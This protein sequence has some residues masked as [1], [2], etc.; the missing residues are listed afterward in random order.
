MKAVAI[1]PA[2]IGSSR[3]PR[4]PLSTLGG[5]LVINR[6]WESVQASGLFEQVIVATDSEE[7]LNAVIVAGGRAQMTRP[8]HPSGS[9]RVAEVAQGLDVYI[10]SNVQ[11]DEPFIDGEALRN[12]L[13]CFD[14]PAVE[15][16]SLMTPCLDPLVLRDPNI[17]KVITDL[18]G[19]ALYFSR[20]PI[21]YD[22]DG[23][24]DHKTMRHIG[25]YAWRKRT[26]LRFVELSPSPLEHCEKLEQLRA[27]E[28]AIPIRMVE[29]AYQ[30][31]GIDTP[32]DLINAERLLCQA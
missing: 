9:D 27:L 8:D 29:T 22:R 6:V 16:A 20:S 12:L 15:M 18:R 4:K 21:P 30:G 11:G 1:I 5:K 26:L 25:V 23:T 17:V 7:I 24:T 3:F 19:N 10:S 13:N 32:G 28:N 31:M 14:D 2:R